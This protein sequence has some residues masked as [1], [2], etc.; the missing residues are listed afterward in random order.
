ME[1]GEVIARG[2]GSEMQAKNV[3]QLVAI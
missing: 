1:R 3:R 2:P